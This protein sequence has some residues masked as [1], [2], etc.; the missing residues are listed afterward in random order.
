MLASFVICRVGA[1]TEYAFSWGITWFG[2]TAGIVFSA[3]FYAGIWLVAV[4]LSMSI[5]L[6]SSTLWYG[7]VSAKWFKVNNLVLDG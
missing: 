7:F 3:A 6:T 2:T 1:A 4:S 5:L